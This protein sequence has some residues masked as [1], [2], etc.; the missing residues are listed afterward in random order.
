MISWFSR[1][2]SYVELS[3]AEAE[4][5]IACSASCEVVW[6]QKLLSNLFDVQIDDTCIH[7]D[8]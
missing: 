6:M 3:T 8:N 2:Q 4:Y 1:K 5:F 7:R